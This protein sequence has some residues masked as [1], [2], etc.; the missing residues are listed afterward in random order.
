MTRALNR[1][2]GVLLGIATKSKTAVSI[3]FSA[4]PMELLR[5]TRMRNR[6]PLR[7]Q[8]KR[9]L[10]NN[11][12]TPYDLDGLRGKAGSFAYQPLISILMPVYNV[13][14]IWLEKAV[15]SVRNQ[16]YGNWELCIV[17]DASPS[18]HVREALE[19]LG[20][21]DPRIKIAW[22]KE[23]RG[24]A[25]ATNEA[26]RLAEGEFV[27]LLDNDDEL[28][29]DA[30]FEVAK[31]LNAHPDADMIYSDEDKL[32]S[33]G[34]RVDP[35][36]KPDWSPDLIFSTMYTCHL[37]VYRREIAEKIG[38][39]REGFDGSQDY[40]FVLRF[41]EE[42]DRI[43][44]I[45]KILYHWRI[46][47]GS[48]A[49]K[50]DAKDS[51]VPSLKALKH[52]MA[53][54]SWNGVVEKG[55]K[56]GSFRIR[57]CLD[58]STLVS[59]VIPCRDKVEL[60]KNC[61]D[62][63]RKKTTWP[64]Y[65]ILVIDNGSRESETLAYLD[66]LGDQ[67]GCRVLSFDAPYNF[68][69]INNLGSR[70]AAGEVLVFLN[71]DTEVKTGDWLEAMLEVGMRE[72]VGAVGPLLLYPDDTIQHAGVILGLGGIAN[73]AFYMKDYEDWTYLN[74]ASIIRNYIAVTGACMM[75]RKEVFDKMDGFDEVNFPIDYNDIDFCLRLW[76]QGYSVVYTP[77]A[78]LYHDE[79]ATL[80][81]RQDREYSDTKA[82]LVPASNPGGVKGESKE[83]PE[84]VKMRA[85]WGSLIANDPFYNPNLARDR[86]DF[87]LN[88]QD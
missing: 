28:T 68:S 66:W 5:L 57:R 17:D 11:T 42:T 59:I 53:R 62:S 15:A 30:L 4:G 25:G 79:G 52:A 69:A 82:K 29:P 48:T 22:L 14:R 70:E 56:M 3:L 74:Q 80:L 18:P 33:S 19:D 7:Y 86:F 26:L 38:G 43:F 85:K 60:T 23:N 51:D 54:R 49:E 46:I 37:G 8:Y 27:G 73:H 12:L 44:H 55:L 67:K 31:L 45:P 72:N 6:K 40:D 81:Q 58:D 10:M 35:Y 71:N 88:I 64:R 77:F 76:E 83:D 21:G 9:W 50:Y 78:V 61:I 24:I 41:V 36:F 75:V 34:E 32:N 13:D 1:L 47:P 16:V 65:E 39:F 84:A 2:K 20:A 87:S 63:I